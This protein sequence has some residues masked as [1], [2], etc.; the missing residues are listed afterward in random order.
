[1]IPC[2]WRSVKEDEGQEVNAPGTH[3]DND[4]NICNINNSADDSN[5]INNVNDNDGYNNDNDL[6]KVIRTSRSVC[7]SLDPRPRAT[8]PLF[9][10]ISH[11]SYLVVMK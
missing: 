10:I 7:W 4:D 2:I 1:M 11:I 3:H 8:L 9:L 6:G 5:T